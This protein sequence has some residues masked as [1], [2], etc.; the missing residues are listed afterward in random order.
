[1]V[2][3]FVYEGEGNGYGVDWDVLGLFSDIV[4]LSSDIV[5]VGVQSW[6]NLEGDVI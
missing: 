3:R 5:L 6:N 2:Q 1:M 4:K